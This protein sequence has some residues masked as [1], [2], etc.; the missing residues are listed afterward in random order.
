MRSLEFFNRKKGL[1][2]DITH[3]CSLECPNC[4]RNYH[5]KRLGRKVYGQDISLDDIKKLARHYKM[6]DFCGQLSDPVHHPK[7]IEILEHLYK[8]KIRVQVHNASSTKSKS[9]YIKAF[10]AHPKAKWIFGIDGLPE[11]S[12]LYRVNQDGKKLYDIMLEAKKHLLEKKQILW[13]YIVFKYNEHNIEKAKEMAQRDGI[14]FLT[15]QSSRWRKRDGKD[16]PLKPSDR[17]AL[18]NKWDDKDKNKKIYEI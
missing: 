8:N 5:F 7:F 14:Y 3:R 18:K 13:Q 1:N 17:Y 15:I 6:W 2:I 11:Q 4:Q 16:D 9:W 10:K 12:H